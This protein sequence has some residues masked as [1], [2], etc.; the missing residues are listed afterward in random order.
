MRAALIALGLCVLSLP[1]VF[2][3]GDGAS[4]ND[5]DDDIGEQ[6]LVLSLSTDTDWLY[7]DGV[8]RATLDATLA[9]SRGNPVDATILIDTDEGEVAP[10]PMDRTGAGR[11]RAYL[12]IYS[13]KQGTAHIR[14]WVEGDPEVSSE[15]EIDYAPFYPDDLVI[16]PGKSEELVVDVP[17]SGELLLNLELYSIGCGWDRDGAES[18]VLDICR[19]DGLCQQPVVFWGHG[20][21]PHSTTLLFGSAEKGEEDF[22]LSIHPRSCCSGSVVIRNYSADVVPFDSEDWEIYRRAPF[23]YQRSDADSTDTVFLMYAERTAGELRYETIFS[24]EDGGTGLVPYLLMSRFG[25]TTDIEWTYSVEYDGQGNVAGEYFQGKLHQT[26]RFNGQRFEAHPFLRV[27][28]K[29][30]M[31]CDYGDSWLLFAP[32]P[33]IPNDAMPRER[34][35][36]SFPLLFWAAN[37]EMMRE[38]KTESE[39]D[40]NSQTLSDERGYV[41]VRLVGSNLSGQR[42]LRV[43]VRYDGE[44]F[45]SDHGAG[46][47]FLISKAGQSAVELG[48]GYEPSK[49]EA[50]G[51]FC[52][53]PDC[54]WS[55]DRVEVYVL[56]DSYELK[57]VLEQQG[58]FEVEG[59]DGQVVIEMEGVR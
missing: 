31:F 5:D 17:E 58:S 23:I 8:Q 11:Y 34:V 16:E 24:N 51:V 57:N 14:A 55:L 15:I 30:G 47:M 50:V 7:S 48:L 25:R 49:L 12:S 2:C 19:A 53:Q 9:D 20:W 39:P 56:D 59:I 54:R 33:L 10:S 45:Y 27:C 18:V 21:G 36:D 38:G 29:N 44:W 41:Y 52:T 3:A 37:V 35:M 46:G 22:S 42:D 1:V 26:K 28:T 32:A 13:E 40:P 4:S 43:G 6:E